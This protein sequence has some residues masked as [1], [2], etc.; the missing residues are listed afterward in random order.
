MTVKNTPRQYRPPALFD[1]DIK[2]W[3]REMGLALIDLVYKIRKD[4]D[5]GTVTFQQETIA[6]IGNVDVTKFDNGQL[7]LVT[8]S[9][10]SKVYL[11]ARVSDA[12]KKVELT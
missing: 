4:L 1:R 10:D 11:V 2:T 5:L 6:G 3:A 7:K 8:D 12:L 9:D